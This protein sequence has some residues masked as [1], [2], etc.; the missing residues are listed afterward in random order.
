MSE[1]LP[2]NTLGDTEVPLLKQIVTNTG[3]GTPT[4][5]FVGGYVIPTFDEQ[6]FTYWGLTNNIKTIAYKSNSALVATQ[7]FTYVGGG[8]SDDDD[9]LAVSIEYP[10]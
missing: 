2:T 1:G 3:G 9:I 5:V 6:V 10:S 8:A 4:Y 7:Y